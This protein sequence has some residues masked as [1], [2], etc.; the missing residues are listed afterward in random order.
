AINPISKSTGFSFE[1]NLVYNGSF[2]NTG[3]GNI[4]GQ[5]PL[6]VNPASGNFDLQA[7]SPAIIGATTLGIID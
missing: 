7:L 1:D 6:F 2:K 3:S 5:D 4:I